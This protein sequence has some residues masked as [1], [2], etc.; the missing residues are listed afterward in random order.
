VLRY[1]WNIFSPFFEIEPPEKKPSEKNPMG[2]PNDLINQM[3]QLS[4]H[5]PRTKLLKK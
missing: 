1:G 5:H 4:F 3:I 2:L